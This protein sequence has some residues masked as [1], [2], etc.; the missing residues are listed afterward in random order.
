MGLVD[1]RETPLTSTEEV[2]AVD[3][4]MRLVGGV[5]PAFVGVLAAGEPRLGVGTAPAEVSSKV[6][7]ARPLRGESLSFVRADEG[8]VRRA[9]DEARS[10]ARNM[11]VVLGM[12]LL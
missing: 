10:E 9:T 5:R 12:L 11:Q 4:E 7:V 1:A 6:G 2:D 8:D 3:K